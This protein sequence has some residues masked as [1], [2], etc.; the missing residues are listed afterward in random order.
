MRTVCAALVLAAAALAHRDRG[1]QV[2][3]V[4]PI[5]ELDL[6]EGINP[7]MLK[8]V[9]KSDQSTGKGLQ[10]VQLVFERIER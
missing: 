5:G 2:P 1:Q 3:Q 6:I 10:L 8:L 7:I 4:V 9:G